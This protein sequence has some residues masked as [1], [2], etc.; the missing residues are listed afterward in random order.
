MTAVRVKFF[1]NQSSNYQGGDGKTIEMERILE[2]LDEVCLCD[3]LSEVIIKLR[4]LGYKDDDFCGEKGDFT[5]RGII[6]ITI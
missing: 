4:R 1:H 3:I 2:V 6:S 5:G